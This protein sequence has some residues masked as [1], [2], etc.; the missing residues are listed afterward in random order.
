MYED[1][2]ARL[3]L[4][5]HADWQRSAAIYG[6]IGIEAGLPV[7][8]ALRNTRLLGI[9]AGV[10]FHTILALSGH[11]AFSSFAIAFYVLFLPDDMPARARRFLSE[12][13]RS[14]ALV[15]RVAATARAPII[16]PLVS[17]LFLAAAAVI[18][19]WPDVP[20]TRFRLEGLMELGAELV[21]YAYTAVLATSAAVILLRY[22]RP[23]RYRPGFLRLAHPVWWLGPALVVLNAASPYVGLKTQN[24]F[25][26]YSNLQ[27]ENGRWNHALL[28][29]EMRVFSLQEDLVRIIDTDDPWLGRYAG[30]D[31]ALVWF[32]FRDYASRNLELRV[33]YERR[34]DHHVVDRARDDPELG[35]PQSP[36][37]AKVL[38][39]RDV[40]PPDENACRSRREY[41]P[42]QGS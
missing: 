3:G 25:T 22:G 17:A 42:E 40:P 6:T 8:L 35:R 2:V 29:A 26:M 19:Y 34:G 12:N 33:T 15:R 28:P 1:L 7:L 18:T 38:F 13:Q 27:T 16:F 20:S 9:A 23:I 31:T 24:S 14:G 11:T 41:T 5:G 36:L 30:T 37:L 21:F 32:K 39:F 10:G 4:P